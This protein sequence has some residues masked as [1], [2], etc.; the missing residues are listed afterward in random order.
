MRL[1]T[2]PRTKIM[3]CKIN[4]IVTYGDILD[5][6]YLSCD[7][8]IAWDELLVH[9]FESNFGYQE[10]THRHHRCHETFKEC[11]ILKWK[12]IQTRPLSFYL[13]KLQ[14]YLYNFPLHLSIIMNIYTCNLIYYS[15][16]YSISLY[17]IIY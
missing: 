4:F 8:V 11:S 6:L 17:I 7:Y 9:F 15:I 10:I 3:Q 2:V 1:L 12:I 5:W 13:I 16:V 14:R